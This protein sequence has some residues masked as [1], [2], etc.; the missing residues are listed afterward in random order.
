MSHPQII[1]ESTFSIERRRI[2]QRILELPPQ[3]DFLIV[4]FIRSN[5]TD[6]PAGSSMFINPHCAVQIAGK[7]SDLLLVRLKPELLI[8]TAA[9]LRVSRIGTQ[10]HFRHP[11][12]ALMGDDRLRNTL[13]SINGELK[14]NDAGW[15]EIIRSQINQLAVY[16]LRSHFNLQK[17]DEVELSRAGIVDRRLR[18]ALEFMHDNCGR[19]LKLS[20]IAAAAYLSDFHFARLFKKITGMTPHGYLASLRIERA[21]KM[22]AETDL[23]IAEIGAQI[24]YTS[25]SHFTKI[26]RESTGMTPR[27]FRVAILKD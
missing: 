20:E 5:I 14:K 7:K 9:R 24:G 3:P 18:R 27:A 22:L 25:Q 12:K 6:S 19:E 11:L 15:R 16:L 4:H 2:N 1:I 21:R 10:L 8:E 13:E 17:S 23:S 26:F